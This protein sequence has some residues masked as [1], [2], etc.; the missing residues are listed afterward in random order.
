ML[1]YVKVKLKCVKI[2][3]YGAVC[4]DRLQTGR[5]VNLT[6]LV[7]LPTNIYRKIYLSIYK[8]LFIYLKIFIIKDL[9][10]LYLFILQ[11]FITKEPI[12]LS[13]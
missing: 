3:I 11:I 12:H 6:D 9:F 7:I 13:N 4:F 2:V 8:D 1:N 10:I 5:Q